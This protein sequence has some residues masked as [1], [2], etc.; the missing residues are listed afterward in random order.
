MPSL[1]TKKERRKPQYL[2]DWIARSIRNGKR[3]PKNEDKGAGIQ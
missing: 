2:H 3:E 1:D